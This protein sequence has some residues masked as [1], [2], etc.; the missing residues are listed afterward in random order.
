MEGTPPQ[1]GWDTPMICVNPLSWKVDEER[2][3]AEAHEGYVASTGD[4]NLDFTGEDKA[5]NVIFES[6]KA[7]E[8]AYT[9]AFCENGRL[10]VAEQPNTSMALGPGNYHGLDFQLFHMNIRK[11][12]AM[13]I[14]AY[15]ERKESY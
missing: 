2:V 3:E 5:E 11:N 8:K 4:Y 15:Y 10:M 13:R 1:E 7:P 6:P 14:S 12:V 9:F